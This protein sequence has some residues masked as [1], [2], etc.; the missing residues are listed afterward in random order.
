MLLILFFTLEG[1]WLSLSD[2]FYD[3]F[4]IF[5][6]SIYPLGIRVDK[7]KNSKYDPNY[8]KI[9][10]IHH[11]NHMI[12]FHFLLILVFDRVESIGY[13]IK[14]NEWIVTFTKLADMDHWENWKIKSIHPTSIIYLNMGF[15]DQLIGWY[16]WYFRMKALLFI[17]WL[18]IL[19]DGEM[20]I[21]RLFYFYWEKEQK[22]MF[23][24]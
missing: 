19:Q 23:K 8:P 10:P 6:L 22:W 15:D 24:T 5:I 21:W 18:F 12:L 14:W 4:F 3:F 20:N 2:G 7:R 11:F 17:M 9:D 16:F 1:C 13:L